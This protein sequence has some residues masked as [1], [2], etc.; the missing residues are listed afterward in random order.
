[1]QV[2]SPRKRSY[3]MFSQFSFPLISI[4]FV[5][6]D[7]LSKHFFL[8]WTSTSYLSS[9]TKDSYL[10]APCLLFKRRHLFSKEKCSFEIYLSQLWLNKLY[11]IL[12][13]SFQFVTDLIQLLNQNELKCY[14]L[15]ILPGIWLLISG[16]KWSYLSTDFSE[17]VPV[18]IPDFES[19]PILG[20]GVFSL[21]P[22]IVRKSA[23]VILQPSGKPSSVSSFPLKYFGAKLPPGLI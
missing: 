8:G 10:F 1:M 2:L 20:R 21:L 6:S 16:R 4:S 12:K 13:C 14:L 23:L 7:D 22:M 15:T 19:A 18:L 3:K 17:G 11:H 9:V 5:L